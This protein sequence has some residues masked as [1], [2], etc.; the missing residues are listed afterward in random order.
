M[1]QHFFGLS[2][3]VNNTQSVAVGTSDT[4]KDVQLVVVDGTANRSQVLL[5]M[6]LIL[7]F[8]ISG[9]SEVGNNTSSTI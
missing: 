9:S 6:R 3:G 4:G 5:L 1:S 2:R 8:F 7:A